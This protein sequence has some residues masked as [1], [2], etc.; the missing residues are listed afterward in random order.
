MDA[1][2]GIAIIGMAC[3][4]PGAPDL[5][6]FWRLLIE[7]REGIRHFSDEDLLSAGVPEATL[8][9]PGYVKAAPVLEGHDLFDAAFF[10][11]SPREARIMDPQQRLL[12]ETAWHAME[13]AG[14]DPVRTEGPVGAFMGGGGVVSSYLLA[15]TGLLGSATGGVEHLGND[16][17]FLATKLSYKL[18]LTG[19]SITVQTACSTSL[20]ATHLA[21]Q[22]IMDGECRMALAGAATV[23]VPHISGYQFR[24]GDILSPDG[25]CRAYDARAQ[26]TVFGSGVGVVVLKH[27]EDALADGDRIYAVIR[28]TA[29]NNDGAAKVS[30]TASSTDGQARCMADAFSSAGIAPSQVGYVEGHGTGTVVG[31]PLEIRALEN[32]FGTDGCWLGSVKTNIGHLEQTAGVASLIKTALALHH[33]QIPPSLNFESPNARIVDAPFQIPTRVTAW[34]DDRRR[35]CVNSLG[36]GGTN[37]F[38]VLEAAPDPGRPARVSHHLLTLSAATS[39]AL[40]QQAETWR[41]AL[42][43]ATDLAGLLFTASQR[44]ALPY[45]LSTTGTDADEIRDSLTRAQHSQAA[46]CKIAFAFP[47]Q[48]TQYTGMA[49]RLRSEEPP[50]R[51]A[52]DRIASHLC[53]R[54]G[55]DI[56]RAI[57]GD[58]DALTETR[59]QQPALFTIGWALAELLRHWGLRPD[60]VIGHS[61]GS[62]AAAAVSGIWSP[63]DASD[64]VAARGRLMGALPPGG[65]MSALLTDEDTARGFLA[66]GA[67]LA[68]INSTANCIVGGSEPAVAMTEQ[69]ARTAGVPVHRLPVSHAF[70]TEAMRPAAEQFAE[71][72]PGNA[73]APRVP[74]VSDMTGAVLDC[75]PDATFLAQHILEPVRFA[76]GLATLAGL[77]IT[78]VLELGPGK[79]LRSFAA[80]TPATSHLRGHGLLNHKDDLAETL[81][82][83]GRLWSHGAQVDIARY[84]R[85]HGVRRTSA[86]L[87]PFQRQRYW[88]EAAAGPPE[89]SLLGTRLRTPSTNTQFQALWSA[90]RQPW[91]ADHRVYGMLCLPVASALITMVEA[92]TKDD[93]GTVEVAD[94]T[95]SQACL[96][97]ETEERLLHTALTSDGSVTLSSAATD[98]EW[99]THIT[100]TLRPGKGLPDA[101]LSEAKTLCREQFDPA[102]FYAALDRIGLNYGPGFRAVRELW[103]GPDTALARIELGT[104]SDAPTAVHPAL[105]D[106][107]LHLFPAVSR[108]HGGFEE[109]SEFDTTFLP[110][111]VERFELTE[112]LPER[113][114][115]LC[116]RRTESHDAPDRYAV[117]IKILSD[118]GECVA[119]IEGLTV[120]EIPRNAFLP[121]PKIPHA[122]WL[123]GIDW[124]ALPDLPAPAGDGGRWLIAGDTE[125]GTAPV[126]EALR[127][128]GETAEVLHMPPADPVNLA[129]LLGHSPLR[130]LVIASA[131]SLPPIMLCSSDHLTRISRAQFELTKSLAELLSEHAR[132]EWGTPRIWIVTRGAQAPLDDR[133]GGEAMHAALWG[134]G[135]ALAL[136][137][138][139]IW[140]GLIDLDD[141]SDPEVLARELLGGHREDQIAL[142]DGRRLA[143]RLVRRKPASPESTPQIRNDRSYLVTG[144]LGTLGLKTAAWLTEHGARHIWL[145]SRRAPSSDQEAVVAALDAQVR[146]ISADVAKADQVEG[147][148][149]QIQAE[150]P[151]LDGVFH[152]AG[153]L[154][155]GI[156]VSM[157]AEQY[158]SVTA[159]KIEGSWV[160]HQA[161]QTL[162]LSHFV[163]FS[164][165]LSLIGSMG[166]I[167]YVAGNCFQDALVAHRRRLGLPATALNWGP[168]EDA[169][170]ATESGERG[171]AIWRARGTEYIPA[172]EGINILGDAL[173]LNS[174]HLG[175][176][177]TDWGRF[178][179]QFETPPA[180]YDDLAAGIAPH[181][182]AADSRQVR[183]AVTRADASERPG[184]LV[185]ALSSMA[186]QTLGLDQPPDPAL[187]LRSVGLDSLMSITLIN[188]IESVFGPRLPAKDLLQGPSIEELASLV[189][190]GMDLDDPQPIPP[191][192]IGGA[193]GQWLVTRQPRPDAQI[194]LFC[195]PFAG[196]GSAVFDDWGG[197]FDPDIEIVAIEPPG[198]LSRIDEAPVRTVEDFAHGLLAQMQPMLD[199]PYAVLG[200]CLGGLTLYE[201]VRTLRGRKAPMPVH[202]FVSGARPPSV[203]RAPGTFEAELETRLRGYTD[204]RAGLAGHEQ[205]D[206]VFI[207]IV[208]AFGISDSLR[209]LEEAELRDLIL[210]TVRA[211][212]EMAYRY[213]YLPDRPFAV[214]IT[215]FRGTRD[216]YVDAVDARIW[217][218]FTSREFELFPRDVGHFAIVEDFEFIRGKVEERLL[219][220]CAETA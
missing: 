158:Q 133:I 162:E 50:F 4:F 116:Q 92:G 220:A 74:F 181:M 112:A 161:T 97:E 213:M 160:L 117:D 166:Q 126:A 186:A 73:K 136:E 127:H 22:S 191:V 83:V 163:L 199:R 25:H 11:Y 36:L 51:E 195:F 9:R 47:G 76:D 211:E 194:R 203:L 157:S 208:R 21:R 177:I 132:P 105:V 1:P 99:Q 131:L 184:L 183:E 182:P 75:P 179:R 26:G 19:P 102:R 30:Y 165:I 212:F 54:H 218:K 66:E 205:S 178:L 143:P 150:G 142:R 118:S 46:K 17:D 52:F 86:P 37:A 110:V 111:S 70:H 5:D 122:D 207:E 84:Y 100:A 140:G 77:G 69:M 12:L 219:R 139:G 20:V 7:G 15:Q 196:G 128:A 10:E 56:A 149:R 152:C 91:L 201:T 210:P 39:E 214:P 217:R 95:Y 120:R 147:L 35:A 93:R 72:A 174:E 67:S 6:A 89:V 40:S 48:G 101:S 138:P 32:I 202:I 216:T 3:R 144:G 27:I 169:G 170:L 104:I 28:G 41:T 151:Q 119:V 90:E 57:D 63:E 156:L 146:V 85:D 198:R 23:R 13:D 59:M 87:Y 65:A 107:C 94:L 187:S 115:S 154:D 192:E 64:L 167:N 134:H 16:K 215:C 155:D 175:V 79:S 130:G 60:A 43:G 185:A 61:V 71:L 188:E 108:R 96:W 24:E 78:D 55:L 109:P 2:R 53:A 31:D 173:A 176:T 159:P 80:S 103:V 38:A 190:A 18:G 123:Y 209:M 34:P 8:R 206:P 81:N 145:V 200:H 125:Y 153:L 204:Y 189:L 49:S 45:R 14:H 58:A 62:F 168:W 106:A 88:L 82:T 68:V 44:P 172:D 124:K 164:S 29:V 113:V 98:E 42:S 114:W 129:K 148:I 33:G 121:R 171:R 141:L 180:L 197:A 137:H 193:S 135:R